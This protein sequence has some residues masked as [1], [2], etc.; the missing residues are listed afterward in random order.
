M[1]NFQISYDK[2]WVQSGD[3][4]TASWNI[5]MADHTVSTV[6]TAWV[7]LTKHVTNDGFWWEYAQESWVDAQAALSG[8]VTCPAAS[9]GI[10]YLLLDITDQQGFSCRGMMQQIQVVQPG[11]IP[12]TASLQITP[13]QPT[14]DDL[15]TITWDVQGS[16][17]STTVNLTW[18]IYEYGYGYTTQD[19]QSLPFQGS[20]TVSMAHEGNLHA[21][22][23][24]R[25]DDL[26]VS[27][28]R[29]LSVEV[30]EPSGITL[31]V[32][33]QNPVIGDQV[34]VEWK[35]DRTDVHDANLWAEAYSGNL[36]KW[37]IG[38]NITGN[39][40]LSG[41]K[42]FT[43]TEGDAFSVNLE[44]YTPNRS[45]SES[46]GRIPIG[47]TWNP[48]P[49]V[50]V[51]VTY[52]S[53]SA[54][55]GDTLRA[56]YAISGSGNYTYINPCWVY[57]APNGEAYFIRERVTNQSTG[58]LDVVANRPGNYYLHF[59]VDDGDWSFNPDWFEEIN[60]PSVPFVS[61][62]GPEIVLPLSIDLYDGY[63]SEVDLTEGFE[64]TW[65]VVGGDAP[66][67]LQTTLHIETDDGWVYHGET[68]D[69]SVPMTD[70]VA[71]GVSHWWWVYA[72]DPSE[73]AASR[74]VTITLTPTSNGISGTPT[75]ITIPVVHHTSGGRVTLPADTVRIEDE[76]FLAV[77]ADE[78][79]LPASLTFIGTNAFPPSAT[80]IVPAN[81]YAESW[82]Q[83]NGYTYQINN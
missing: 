27:F 14:V 45:F 54:T 29:E 62:I 17:P 70:P 28:S 78:F 38:D 9:G 72:Q 55:T 46:S 42:T 16:T 68:G 19:K 30:H 7:T 81:S 82:A 69:G 35:I 44:A 12:L 48:P 77:A 21:R 56:T 50:S 25:D 74:T 33:P 83:A 66:Y 52:A 37:L 2:D 23:E 58:T 80:L 8:S 10:V 4:I 51:S 67:N 1:P 79:V 63:P 53:T 26:N 6:R 31:S 13:N 15:L 57:K 64:L 49:R 73:V 22:L 40:I 41:K 65:D 20:E 18:D 60:D 59:T 34:T 32:S 71:Y 39:D 61:V 11:S 47:G 43:L 5:D 36:S 75:S 76:A 3:P 24:V